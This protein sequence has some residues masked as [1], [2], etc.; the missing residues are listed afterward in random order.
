MKDGAGSRHMKRSGISDG[1][2]L[3]FILGASGSSVG[4]WELHKAHL[5][6]RKV[7]SWC[8]RTLTDLE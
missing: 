6:K 7:G 4:L 8:L 3:V 5:G 2:R 1:W